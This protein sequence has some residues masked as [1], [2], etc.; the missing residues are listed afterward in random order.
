MIVTA[1]LPP[2]ALAAAGFLVG[3]IPVGYLLAL[4]KG[5]D[6]RAQGS[7]NIGATNVGRVLGKELGIL[8]FVLDVLKGFLPVIAAS[9]LLG[10]PREPSRMFDT[11]TALAWLAVVAATI[12]G[13]IFTPWLGFKGGKG[14][15]TGLGALLGVFPLF[16]IPVLI[17]AALWLASLRVWR[18]VGLS[19]VLAAAALPPLVVLVGAGL[20]LTGLLGA[21]ENH[22]LDALP[23]ALA[24]YAGVAALLAALVVVRHRG[25]LRRIRA[26]T[27]PK[28]GWIAKKGTGS[29]H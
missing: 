4:A 8:C 3:S 14:V 29:R 1:P 7:G 16:T 18:Y 24:P 22:S 12:L 15:A 21:P 26:G 19:S 25:N 5:V 28:V 6:I 10:M 17:A 27:E 2:P 9:F 23:A 20:L 11:P 13:H